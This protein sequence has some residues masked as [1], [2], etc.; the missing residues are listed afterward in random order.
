MTHVS[1]FYLEN[2]TSKV[3]VTTLDVFDEQK[4]HVEHLQTDLDFL[5]KVVTGDESWVYVYDPKTKQQSS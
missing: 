5:S 4:R 1:G 2:W 3:R